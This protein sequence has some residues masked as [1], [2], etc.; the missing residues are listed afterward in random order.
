MNT[1]RPAMMQAAFYCRSGPA[2][3]VLEIGQLPTPEPAHGEVLVRIAASGVN[4]HDTK[5]RSG[6]TGAP[7]AAGRV[8][9]HIDG[10][11][12]IV[13]TGAGVASARV[14]E[15]VF[16]FS[17]NLGEHGMGTAAEYA[18]VPAA[19]AIALPADVSFAEGASLGVPA[20]TAYYA[21]LAD[22]PVA[23][24]TLLV[25][26][27]AGAVGAVA[28]ELARWN[29]ATVIATVSSPAK[30]EIARGAGADH[31]IDYRTEDVAARVKALTGGRGVDRI[32]EVDFGANL[33]VD[34]ACLKPNG[35]IASYSST[36]VRE[37]A[38]PYYAFALLGGARIHVLQAGNLPPVVQEQGCAT[39]AALLRRGMLRPRLAARFP[40][41]DIAA[42]HELLES[43]STTGNIVVELAS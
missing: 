23:G 2:R 24:Q 28:I 25:Q 18:A 31:I 33:A 1:T 22:G 41:S 43:G 14:G 7:M 6:W 39:I 42:A 40:L 29:G 10:A 32:V 19:N 15:R 17:A 20:L 36:Q 21:V 12:T 3:E 34:A 4:P 30:A 27:G 5:K 26:G 8:I 9:P 16:V 38:F 37:P 11:G 13:A 35:V